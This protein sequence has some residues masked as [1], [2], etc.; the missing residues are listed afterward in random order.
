MAERVVGAGYPLRVF[1][2]TAAKS[3][4][5][6]A[7][8]A[9][10][11]ASVAELASACDAVLLCLTDTRAV[12]EVVFGS[13]GIAASAA[14]GTLIIDLSTTQPTQARVM[15]E[16]LRRDHGMALV[17][18]PVSGGPPGARAGTLAVM[19]GGDAP[20]VER[21]R[22]LL[23]CFARQVVHMGPPGCGQATKACNQMI[24]FANSAAIAEAMN[25]AARFG[26]DPAL[27]PQALSGGFADSGFLRHFGP[28]MASGGYAGA[29]NGHMTLKDLK[30]VEDLAQATGSAM[31]VIGLIASLYRLLFAQGFERDGVA[32]LM[33][34]YETA[35]K[36]DAPARSS[37]D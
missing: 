29:G 10:P 19:V 36:V 37:R 17:D 3:A 11:S 8:G 32:G 35:G 12:E 18:A 9:V 7:A 25:L 14:V 13:E 4:A 6:L 26:M 21:A 33:R 23:E 15:A 20:D 16:R 28:L 31:P 5:L 27:L 34:L 30:I 22:P 24:N 1:N 2:R